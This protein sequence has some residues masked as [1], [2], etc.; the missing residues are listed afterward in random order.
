M[1]LSSDKDGCNALPPTATM[2][3]PVCHDVIESVLPVLEQF[4]TI[5][6]TVAMSMTCHGLRNE[7]VDQSTNDIKISHFDTSPERL[8]EMLHNGNSARSRSVFIQNALTRIHFPSL[9]SLNVD[10]SSAARQPSIVQDIFSCLVSTIALATKLRKLRLEALELLTLPTEV[11]IA[12]K[13][14]M[15]AFGRNLEECCPDLIELNISVGSW[16]WLY[17]RGPIGDFVRML[18]GVVCKKQ[19]TLENFSFSWEFEFEEEEDL[20]AA[21]DVIDLFSSI[22]ELERL[23]N[24]SLDIRCPFMSEML[25]RAIKSN[26]MKEGS[27]NIASLQNLQISMEEDHDEFA[28]ECS[29][30]H[31]LDYVDR[32]TEIKQLNLSLPRRCFQDSRSLSAWK[33]FMINRQHITHLMLGFDSYSD[34]DDWIVKVLASLLEKSTSLVYFH[35]WSLKNVNR[36]LLIEVINN[37]LRERG[38]RLKE[39]AIMVR[40]GRRRILME[41]LLVAGPKRV[42][43]NVLTSETPSDFK[44][45]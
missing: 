38:H 25:L 16:V 44:F 35:C 45:I 22:F 24:L 39:D 18:R 9:H 8:A 7:I 19:E 5:R 37:L 2:Q 40:N 42:D 6:D 3:S 14:T 20:D 33:R 41:D 13:P 23:H 27:L 10:L 17:R 34:D 21:D 32:F 30:A 43:C 29:H 15:E 12:M 26:S 11:D 31:L 4:L 28:S 1:M 36:K